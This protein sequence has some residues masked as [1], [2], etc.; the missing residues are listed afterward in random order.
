MRKV[1]CCMLLMVPL[2]VMAQG[3]G[4]ADAV[5]AD[6]NYLWGEGHGATVKE[7]DNNA[8]ADLMSKIS[9]QIESDFTI[10]E[11]EVNTAEGNDAQS[12]VSN[13]ATASRARPAPS[14]S[15]TSMSTAS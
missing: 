10:D 6:P 9:V 13:V 15:K 12:T 2:W 5:K 1:I 4:Q 3:G 14:A 11:R 8:L 7:A